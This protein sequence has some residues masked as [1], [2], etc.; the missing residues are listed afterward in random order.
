MSYINTPTTSPVSGCNGEN[1]CIGEKL[2]GFSNCGGFLYTCMY[3]NDT[4][5]VNCTGVEG[6]DT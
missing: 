5:S 4:N 6:T 2:S 3:M 1:C